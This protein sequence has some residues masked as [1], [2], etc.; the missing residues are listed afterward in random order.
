MRV[1]AK[2]EMKGRAANEQSWNK[3]PFVDLNHALQLCVSN[4]LSLSGTPTA[5]V[6]AIATP[7]T[8]MIY[9]SEALSE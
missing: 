1:P 5:T 3:F 9:L 7:A 8:L 2:R 6:T 4:A